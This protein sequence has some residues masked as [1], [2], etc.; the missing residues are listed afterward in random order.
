MFSLTKSEEEKNLI[1]DIVEYNINNWKSNLK[2]QGNKKSK[3]SF[4][5]R[6][7]WL[8]NYKYAM[9]LGIVS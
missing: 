4:N 8:E 5:F 2:E 7:F 6:G 3:E 9:K 1:R